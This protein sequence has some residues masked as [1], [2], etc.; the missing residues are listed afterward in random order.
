MASK[1]S[2]SL[3]GAIAAMKPQKVMR[4]VPWHEILKQRNPEL[5]LQVCEVA[6]EWNS[7]GHARNVFPAASMLLDFLK[8]QTVDVDGGSI[9]GDLRP[10]TFRLWIRSRKAGE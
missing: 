2:A 9:I 3:T 1:K 4:T 6:D 7:G 5:Y 10:N 8:A